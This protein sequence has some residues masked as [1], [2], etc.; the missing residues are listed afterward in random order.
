MFL[1][2]AL[3]VFH[4]NDS[5]RHQKKYKRQ[6]V[7]DNDL[8]LCGRINSFAKISSLERVKDLGTV[9]D[10]FLVED[11]IPINVPNSHREQES[12]VGS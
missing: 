8:N 10:F 2:E 1:D 7:A 4:S 6:Q 12:K 5:I 3:N 11:D 9:L